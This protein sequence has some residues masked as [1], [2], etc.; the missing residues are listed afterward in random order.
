MSKAV[1]M[2]V[3]REGNLEAVDILFTRRRLEDFW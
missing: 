1:H 3:G 2:Y